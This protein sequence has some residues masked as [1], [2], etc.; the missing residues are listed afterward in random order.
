MSATP[1]QKASAHADGPISDLPRS[2]ADLRV[3]LAGLRSG[4]LGMSDYVAQLQAHFE[5]REPQIRAFVHEEGRFDRLRREARALERRYPEPEMRPPL[6]GVTLGVKDIFHVSGL[7]TRAGSKLPE[8]QFQGREAAVVTALKKAGALVLGK[9][10]T[11]EFAYFA[12]GPTRN[13]HNLA[14]TPGGSSSGSAAA[15]AAGLCPLAL[16]TQ[17]IGSVNRPA[18]FCGVVGFKPSYDRISRDGVIPLSP[19]LDHVG[20]F[21]RDLFS[22][23]LAASLV[24]ARW[25]PPDL[26]RDAAS[27][28][29]LGIPSG[30]Y[31]QR[32]SAEG[33][34]HFQTT[35]AKL[36]RAGFE[37]KEVPAMPGF[38]AIEVRHTALMAAEAAQVHE[39]WFAK[40]DHLYHPKTAALLTRGATVS[41][42]DV[43]AAREGRA[44][45][46]RELMDLME[47]QGLDGWIAPAAPGTAPRGLDSTGDPVMNLP[48]THSGLPSLT[49]PSGFDHEGLP[50]GLQLVGRWMSDERLLAQAAAVD[51]ELNG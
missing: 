14:H 50:F 3:L 43:A 47:G 16:G 44:R 45:L 5:Q 40:F 23:T 49:L 25:R 31:L 15:V 9:T 51:N 2:L 18:A 10:V 21:T 39:A 30:P 29:V 22:M 33:L 26:P 4:V 28:P 35:C 41:A 24:L 37:I 27:V 11:T 19:S 7:P 32:A 17:T 42:I 8:S 34:A 12:P 46:R 36:V 48:W 6:Y 38:E 13:P 20:L 1:E